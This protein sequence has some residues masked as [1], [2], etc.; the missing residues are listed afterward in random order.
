LPKVTSEGVLKVLSVEDEECRPDPLHRIT[1]RHPWM[2]RDWF[3]YCRAELPHFAPM[4]QFARVNFERRGS[5]P[6]TRKIS[7]C[8]DLRCIFI[9][10]N[11]F[12]LFD[13]LQKIVTSWIRSAPHWVTTDD[14]LR[15]EFE[16]HTC[17]SVRSGEMAS[18]VQ[19]STVRSVLDLP[20]RESPVYRKH[21]WVWKPTQRRQPSVSGNVF[22]V[23]II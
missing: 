16:Q 12:S 17:A 3:N 10:K 5:S 1:G 9:R 15:S 13:D 2:E 6:R 7:E 4:G 21:D 18:G 19:P 11:Q 20:E 23:Y 8:Q 22:T 14:R